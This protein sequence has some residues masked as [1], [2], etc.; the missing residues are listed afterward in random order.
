VVCAAAPARNIPNS[1][2]PNRHDLALAAVF[3]TGLHRTSSATGS[4]PLRMKVSRHLWDATMCAYAT[5]SDF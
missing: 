2:S 5:S 4:Q 3:I 1:G